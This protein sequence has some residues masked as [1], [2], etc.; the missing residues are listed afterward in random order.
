MGPPGIGKSRLVGETVHRAGARGIQVHGAFC[1]SHA[2]DIP[3]RVA[4]RLLR[5]VFGIEDAVHDVARIRV[6]SQ[7]P[8]ADA[9]DLLLLDDLLAIGEAGVDMPIVTPTPADGGSPRC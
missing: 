3:F 5:N 9:Q 4:T 1:E 7:V 6:R 8:D 2:R